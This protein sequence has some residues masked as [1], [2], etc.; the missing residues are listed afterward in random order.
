M[1]KMQK[2]K[3]GGETGA[4]AAVVL[5]G[6]AGEAIFRTANGC[7]CVEFVKPLLFVFGDAKI[8]CSGIE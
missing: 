2:A 8:H 5:A 3:Q 7:F 6:S 1:G 4:G